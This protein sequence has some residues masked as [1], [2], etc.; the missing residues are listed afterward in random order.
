[1]NDPAEKRNRKD[2]DPYIIDDS[3]EEALTYEKVFGVDK[4]VDKNENTKED[5]GCSE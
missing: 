2:F 3:F 5:E 4:G 1:M